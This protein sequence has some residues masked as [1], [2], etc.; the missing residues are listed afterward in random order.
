V[1]IKITSGERFFLVV[2]AVP[3]IGFSL[4][5]FVGAF[6]GWVG[7]AL[8]LSALRWE[9]FHLTRNVGANDRMTRFLLALAL[10]GFSL[11]GRVGPIPGWVGFEVLLTAL[12]AWSPLYALMNYNPQRRSPE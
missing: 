1:K 4:A 9:R 5:G 11:S 7:V 3:L 12:I 8:F 6:P 2:L 10:I